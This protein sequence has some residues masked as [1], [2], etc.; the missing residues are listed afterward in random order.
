LSLTSGANSPP[1]T[2]DPA[3]TTAIA[4]YQNIRMLL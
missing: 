3:I 4:K 2:N 1:G